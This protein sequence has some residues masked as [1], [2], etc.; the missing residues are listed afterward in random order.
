MPPSTFTSRRRGTTSR[1]R[2]PPSTSRQADALADRPS[3]ARLPPRARDHPEPAVA[4][5]GPDR[6][7]ARARRIGPA[8]P[9]D[10]LLPQHR[11]DDQA[12]HVDAHGH[13]RLF[14]IPQDRR[15]R[16]GARHRDGTDRRDAARRRPVQGPPRGAGAR[17][18]SGMID[19]GRYRAWR[20]VH[21]DVV[22]DEN[23]PSGGL[24]VTPR[25][26]IEMV[27]GD[28]SIRQSLLLLLS[29]SPGERVMRP[30]YGCNLQR[31]VF[32]PND[33]TTAGLAI[34]YVRQAVE[35]WEPRVEVLDVDAG[36]DPDDPWRLV[37]L[38]DYRVRA[39]L[40][41]GQLVFSVDL[42]PVDDESGEEG[43]A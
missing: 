28:A 21:P 39:S 30:P 26:R 23:T 34:H 9:L 40:S 17:I 1:S 2:R 13:G 7:R 38:L 25:G 29:T 10:R 43:P 18:G 24:Q 5:P 20:F 27:E 31:L 37:I 4:D 3:S 12:V 33:D 14:D 8:G 32:G 22:L 42:L 16:G 36:P 15:A 35:R 11:A 6:R 41:P 19:Q